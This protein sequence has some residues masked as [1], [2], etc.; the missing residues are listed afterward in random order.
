MPYRVLEIVAAPLHQAHRVLRSL[1]S[2]GV[3]LLGDR[4]HVLSGEPPEDDRQFVEALRASGIEVAGMREVMPS[5]EDVF[6]ALQRPAPA[7][8]VQRGEISGEFS[9]EIT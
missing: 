1:S 5:M 4:L 7:F 2:G 3:Q 6:L 8:P 9:S